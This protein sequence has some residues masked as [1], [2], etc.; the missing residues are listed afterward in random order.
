MVL[1]R[2]KWKVYKKVRFEAS[3]CRYN[4]LTE[5]KSVIE[6]GKYEDRKEPGYH[7]ALRNHTEDAQ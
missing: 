3:P 2:E 1:G 6:D 5:H 7:T 4:V